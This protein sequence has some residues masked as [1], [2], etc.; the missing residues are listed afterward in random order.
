MQENAKDAK[1][2]SLQVID[3]SFKSV[4]LLLTERKNVLI[5]QISS[6]YDAGKKSL[7]CA[8]NKF[9]IL[10]RLLE[11]SETALDMAGQVS[12]ITIMADLKKQLEELF[13]SLNLDQVDA[14]PIDLPQTGEVQR[15]PSCEVFGVMNTLFNQCKGNVQVD[16]KKREVAAIQYLLDQVNGQIQSRLFTFDQN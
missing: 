6:N 5:E 14:T 1:E 4:E 12:N 9:V 15:N 16:I 3:D 8:N 10:K 2:K 13:T 7:E 11:Y